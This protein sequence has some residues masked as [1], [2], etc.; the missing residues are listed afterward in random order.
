LTPQLTPNLPKQGKIDTENLPP[1]LAEIVAIW[2]TLPESVKQA[3]RALIQPN[4]R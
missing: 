3:L 4:D 1:D 2:P